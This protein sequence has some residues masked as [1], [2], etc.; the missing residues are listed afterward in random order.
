MLSRDEIS[1]IAFYKSSNIFTTKLR[2]FQMNASNYRQPVDMMTALEGQQQYVD[3]KFDATPEIKERTFGFSVSVNG[4]NSFDNTTTS[5]GL[6]NTVYQE[7]RPILF[8]Q[9]SGL[10]LL[11]N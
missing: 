5:G 3:T 7:M 2:T 10:N 9:R 1:N 4:S 6:R 8:C 11:N